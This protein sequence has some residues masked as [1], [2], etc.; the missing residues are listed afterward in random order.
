[1][2]T[3]IM[4]ISKHTLAIVRATKLMPCIHINIYTPKEYKLGSVKRVL[5]EIMK[6]LP[7]AM[8]RRIPFLCET[9]EL[10]VTKTECCQIGR[11]IV[12]WILPV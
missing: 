1:M 4:W 7:V 3:F 2:K 9:T 11:L 6:E 12:N 8:Y 5:H 10:T